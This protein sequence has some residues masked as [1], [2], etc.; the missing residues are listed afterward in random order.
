MSVGTRCRGSA[1]VA[2]AT[3]FTGALVATPTHASF[4][5]WEITE[6]YSNADGTIQYVELSTSLPGPI[7]L[8]SS[9][10][11]PWCHGATR[12]AFD[13]DAFNRPIVR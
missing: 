8:A 12:T 5:D 13:L 11:V 3:L 10:L 7:C 2:L 4:H 6:V 1:W 9:P